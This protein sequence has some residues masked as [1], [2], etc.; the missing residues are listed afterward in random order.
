M[1]TIKDYQIGDKLKVRFRKDMPI[2][3]VVIES[4]EESDPKGKR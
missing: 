3:E 4:W 1:L 2:W